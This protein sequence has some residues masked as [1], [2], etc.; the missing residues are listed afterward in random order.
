MSYMQQIQQPLTIQKVIQFLQYLHQQDIITK[1]NTLQ[2]ELSTLQQ[3]NKELLHQYHFLQEQQITIQEDFQTF[4]N[5]LNHAQTFIS[6]TE[7]PAQ[8]SLAPIFEVNQHGQIDIID[9]L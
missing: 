1:E 2:R 7:V 9:I 6:T 4:A 3:V 5:I 8:S